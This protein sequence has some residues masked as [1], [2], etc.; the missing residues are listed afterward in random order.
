MIDRLYY[1]ITR[2]WLVGCFASS[3]QHLT[4]FRSYVSFFCSSGRLPGISILLIPLSSEFVDALCIATVLGFLSETGT[5]W[6]SR[7]GTIDSKVAATAD[8]EPHPQRRLM[9]TH[10]TTLDTRR[11][12][13]QRQG[14][15]SSS[16]ELGLSATSSKKSAPFNATAGVSEAPFARLPLG[17][18]PW[19]GPKTVTAS[20]KPLRA[21][22]GRRIM[23]F[24]PGTPKPGRTIPTTTRTPPSP[25]HELEGEAPRGL[26][27]SVPSFPA[28]VAEPSSKLTSRPVGVFPQTAALVRGDS[29]MPGRE[30]KLSDSR[31]AVEKATPYPLGSQEDE[32]RSVHWG[33]AL[34]ASVELVLTV[35][36][37]ETQ[38]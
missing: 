13:A 32:L 29:D 16:C 8:Y 20:A 9:N 6:L 36:R 37:D 23:S 33:L 5:K 10:S 27:G 4:L 11:V 19:G 2:D 14:N 30:G 22:S 26:S 35:I 28:S 15:L 38:S 1:Y 31:G 25:F 18:K 24:G 17:E 12:L 7:Y 3:H 21:S 34:V